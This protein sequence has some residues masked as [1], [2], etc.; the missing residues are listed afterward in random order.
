MTKNTVQRVL[1]SSQGFAEATSTIGV[2][3][4]MK[5]TTPKVAQ[6]QGVRTKPTIGWG[7]S[8]H[9]LPLNGEKT[10]KRIDPPLMQSQST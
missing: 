4:S 10:R 8:Q 5:T 7:A 6:F 9:I 2:K 3:T 1:L